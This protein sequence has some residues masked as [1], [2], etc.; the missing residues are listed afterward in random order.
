[1]SLVRTSLILFAAAVTVGALPVEAGAQ[2]VH[3]VE[4]VFPDPNTADVGPNPVF[5]ASSG[6]LSG[7]PTPLGWQ[8]ADPDNSASLIY[9]HSSAELGNPSNTAALRGVVRTPPINDSS[10]SWSNDTIGFRLIVDDSVKRLVLGLGRDHTTLARQVVV[11]GAPSVAPIPFPWDNSFHNIFEINR[12]A[13]GNFTITATNGDPALVDAPITVIVPAAALPLSTGAAMFAWGMGADAGGV[14]QWLEVRGRVEQGVLPFT[15]FVAGAQ[16]A[17]GP[18]ADDDRFAVEA[19]FRLGAGSDGINA[20][21]E[22]V[23]LDVGAGSWVIPAGS[24]RRTRIGSFVFQGVIGSAHLGVVIRP[25][26]D[27]RFVFGAAATGAALDG[28]A[29]PVSVSL[30]IGDDGGTTEVIGWFIQPN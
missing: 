12:L 7:T 28:T 8:I 11:L 4:Y 21:T 1:M 26:R 5:W 24:F 17:L 18:G 13:N 20:L 15:S 16:I 25:L 29:N 3:S 2:V 30:T 14:S 6:G 10:T 9:F 23:R 19:L 27:G 22:D